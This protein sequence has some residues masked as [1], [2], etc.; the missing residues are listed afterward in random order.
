MLTRIVKLALSQ[1]FSLQ[2][3]AAL[4][5]SVMI[6]GAVT[7]P[8][9][10]EAIQTRN[11]ADSSSDDSAGAA[12]ASGDSSGEPSPFPPGAAPQGNLS[13]DPSD[14]PTVDPTPT[15]D[16]DDADDDPS[17]GEEVAA[18]ATPEPTP[19]DDPAPGGDVT[20][21]PTPLPDIVLDPTPTPDVPVDATPT[22]QPTATNPTPTPVGTPVPTPAVT[23][24]PTV[25]PPPPTPV[26]TPE[27]TVVAPTPTPVAT[28]DP[29][30]TT[31]P[32]PIPTP[33][34][35]LR[36]DLRVVVNA[37]D[38]LAVGVES[39]VTISVVN[40][41]PA[42]SPSATLAV[43]VEGAQPADVAGCTHN[44]ASGLVCELG[45][46]P[47]ASSID[48]VVP[49]TAAN[50]GPVR[51][52][53]AVKGGAED[54][55]PENN[56][57][58][59][60]VDAVLVADLGIELGPIEGV[61]TDDGA[62]PAR[63][64]ITVP[65]IVVNNG[66]APEVDGAV[67]A[68]TL[69][70]LTTGTLP[71]GCE[72]VDDVTVE[73]SLATV[74][75]RPSSF[76]LEATVVDSDQISV[77]ASITADVIDANPSN[78][79]ASLTAAVVVA[80]DLA[81]EL[82]PVGDLVRGETGV[83]ALVVTNH[84]PSPVTGVDVTLSAAG[85][86]ATATR[87]DNPDCVISNGGLSCQF[88]QLDTDESRTIY[89]RLAVGDVDT[90]TITATVTS[91]TLDPDLSNNT[92]VTGPD[93]PPYETVEEAPEVVYVNEIEGDATI[94][95]NTS[96]SCGAD[97]TVA[98]G[99]SE[100]TCGEI[101]DTRDVITDFG[102][103]MSRNNFWPMRHVDA[104]QVDVPNTFDENSSA[105][106]LVIPAGA[107]VDFAGLYWSAS[108]SPVARSEQVLLSVQPFGE[109][110]D[111]LTDY[112]TVTADT[113]QSDSGAYQGF[114]DVTNLITGPGTV[115]VAG[116]DAQLAANEYA[117][118]SLVVVW[119]GGETTRNITVFDSFERVNRRNPL[120]LEIGGFATPADGQLQLGMTSYEGD[121]GLVGESLVIT[122]F[123]ADGN[124]SGGTAYADAVNPVDDV[125]N[126]TISRF[127]ELITGPGDTSHLPSYANTLGFDLDVFSIDAPAATTVTFDYTTRGDVYWVGPILLSSAR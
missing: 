118:W 47:G 44:D 25:T 93:H 32:T 37:P 43:A 90:V 64:R 15:P 73:C 23:P 60:S 76:G 106:D 46:Q 104:D 121:I 108:R 122:T 8:L 45:S 38:R 35:D 62:V 87:F 18:E 89:V 28:P 58:G 114:T 125:F 100:L 30:P 55:N 48:V 102:V 56:S 116:I 69:S 81:V 7:A 39:V 82:A 12:G 97:D 117:G 84:G 53:A 120:S 65:V 88:S 127:G 31:E 124:P 70:G 33:T 91:T 1:L 54:P 109:T 85:A 96:L 13:S 75:A 49:I 24:Q 111:D 2:V 22:P 41:G 68:L 26:A 112:T 77:A 86:D 50:P 107:T 94:I 59:A 11:A 110:P 17:P 63:G 27:P 5:M 51:V 119:N 3:A 79:S 92:F 61:V 20:P 16:P 115:W 40:D 34:P 4:A 83:V 52:V 57:A 105:A 9:A 14:D 101:R 21:T 113:I 126:S 6:T 74:T 98:I 67:V 78:D 123:D 95:G 99:P 42:D 10:T 71:L 66:P 103:V 72:L 80:A 29:T 19:N 36:A